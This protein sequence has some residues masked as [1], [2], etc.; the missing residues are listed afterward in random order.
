MDFRDF[1][2]LHWIFMDSGSLKSVV[3]PFSTIE[4]ANMGDAKK[5]SDAKETSDKH[6][7]HR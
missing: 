3:S 5:T 4:M 1:K 6:S 7:V 2:D